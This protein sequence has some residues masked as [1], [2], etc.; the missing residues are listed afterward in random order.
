MFVVPGDRSVLTV[1][2]KLQKRGNVVPHKDRNNLEIVV[3]AA[4]L[5]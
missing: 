5:C 3:A 1:K 2:V 4:L